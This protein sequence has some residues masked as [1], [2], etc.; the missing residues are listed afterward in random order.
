[1]LLKQYLQQYLKCN[2]RAFALLEISIALVIL[3]I[4]MYILMSQFAILRKIQAN[5][6]TRE[7]IE[8]ILKALGKC[9]CYRGQYSPSPQQIDENGFGKV[10]YDE[11][12]IPVAYAKD[13]YGKWLCYKL[14]YDIVQGTPS[15]DMLSAD[16]LSANRK[17][18]KSM[19]RANNISS[20]SRPLRSNALRGSTL[21][22]SSNKNWWRNVDET[23]YITLCAQR[24]SDNKSEKYYLKKSITLSDFEQFYVNDYRLDKYDGYSRKIG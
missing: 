15:A 9:Y 5:T 3:G 16:V 10:P 12:H 13:G 19:S 2:L 11:L 7:H 8:Y 24:S 6:I 17:V 22:S 14:H 18:Y 1:M 23:S 21:R 20:T 4:I